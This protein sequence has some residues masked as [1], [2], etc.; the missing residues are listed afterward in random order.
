M[1]LH[2]AAAM[3]VGTSTGRRKEAGVGAARRCEYVGLARELLACQQGPGGP[4]SKKGAESH[5][6]QAPES[7]TTKNNVGSWMG[8]LFC[9]SAATFFSRHF[10]LFFLLL[11]KTL[12]VFTLL[13]I[14][15][16]YQIIFKK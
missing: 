6:S 1:G 3:I 12:H 11:P 7:L 5:T 2:G 13:Y 9:H 4:Y 15:K 14:S 16:K 8:P 10:F